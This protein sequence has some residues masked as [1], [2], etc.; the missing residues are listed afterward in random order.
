MYL[1]WLSREL[2][3][4]CLGMTVLLWGVAL[5]HGSFSRRAQR[6]YMNKLADTNQA[7]PSQHWHA[8]CE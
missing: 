3:L 2:A 8:L 1:T 4:A 7:S 5:R 6:A